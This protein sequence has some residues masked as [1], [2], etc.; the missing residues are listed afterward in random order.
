MSEPQ[1]VTISRFLGLKTVVA[2][3]KLGLEEA[4]NLENIE[5]STD[6]LR[7]RDGYKRRRVARVDGTRPILGAWRVVKASNLQAQEL[8]HTRDKFWRFSGSAVASVTG[9]YVF[10]SGHAHTV[11][12]YD[13]KVW[14]GNG[15]DTGWSYSF[16]A[17]KLKSDSTPSQAFRYQE[18][19]EEKRVFGRGTTDKS[20]FEWTDEGAPTTRQALAFAFYP[21]DQSDDLTLMRALNGEIILASQWRLGKTVGGLPPR[22]IVDIHLGIGCVSH[23]SSAVLNGWLYFVGMAGRIYRTD[24]NA[25]E[26]AA[27]GLDTSDISIATPRMLRGV[28]RDGRYYDLSYNSKAAGGTFPNRVL[29]YDSWRDRWYGP[30]VIGGAGKPGAWCEWRTPGDT[31][32]IRGGTTSGYAATWWS[33]NSDAGTTIVGIYK[34]PIFHAPSP[35]YLK[36][37]DEMEIQGD[38]ITSGTARIGLYLDRKASASTVGSVALKASGVVEGDRDATTVTRTHLYVPMKPTVTMTCREYQPK[39]RLVGKGKPTVSRVVIKAKIIRS[40]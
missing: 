2:A 25:V 13:N 7:V 19:F 6:E 32:Q 31:G 12:V 5:C 1:Y 18:A 34:G 39:I 21:P 14:G 40:N 9:A 15:G 10:T 3:D 28:A 36:L 33:G 4:A 30:H 17:A 8:L 38:D 29:T 24:G 37:I 23:Y 35:T 26:D 27:L 20:R 11:I 16:A 22:A